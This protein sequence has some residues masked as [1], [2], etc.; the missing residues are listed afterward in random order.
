MK[1]VSKGE[2]PAWICRSPSERSRQRSEPFCTTFAETPKG[3]PE[4][5]FQL[6]TWWRIK[7][8]VGGDG[9]LWPI[10][11]LLPC[12]NEFR[13]PGFR[14]SEE[15]KKNPKNVAGLDIGCAAD[16]P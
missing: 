16:S 4:I 2:V 9:L 15:K 7:L 14:I 10:S 6:S 12:T 5:E 1:S 13:D 3:V 8:A 11:P